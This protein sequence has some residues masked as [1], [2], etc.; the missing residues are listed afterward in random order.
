MYCG[1][2]CVVY[3]LKAYDT[4]G[5]GIIRITP[6]DKKKFADA[7]IKLLSDE[8]LRMMKGKTV[9]RMVSRFNWDEIALKHESELER[10]LK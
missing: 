6:G 8:K 10:V 7:I 4:F 9:K 1:L 2:P 3:S 5:D